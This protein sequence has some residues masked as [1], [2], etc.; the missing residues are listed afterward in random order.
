MEAGTS[1]N[2]RQVQLKVGGFVKTSLQDAVDPQQKVEVF[3]SRNVESMGLDS[4]RRA[5]NPFKSSGIGL[6]WWRSG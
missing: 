6:P 1:G 5:L 4:G 3:Y 2:G